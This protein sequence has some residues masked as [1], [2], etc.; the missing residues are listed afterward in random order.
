MLRQE[1]NGIYFAD[2]GRLIARFDQ[3]DEAR[4]EQNFQAVEAFGPE[5]RPAHPLCAG[6]H[7]GLYLPRG[8]AQKCPQL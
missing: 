4:V 7:H 8:P 3:P 1:N 6:A 2:G 5:H